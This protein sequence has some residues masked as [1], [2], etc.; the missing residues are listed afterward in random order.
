MALIKYKYGFLFI[1]DFICYI[2]T[3]PWFAMLSLFVSCFHT[4]TEEEK[5]PSRKYLHYLI[6]APILGLM[7]ICTFPMA[8]LGYISWILICNFF[9]VPDYAVL[10]YPEDRAEETKSKYTFVSANLLLGIE[11]MGK[12]QNMPFVYNRLAKI[13]KS[14]QSI[15]RERSPSEPICNAPILEDPKISDEELMDTS[16]SHKW[17]QV[18]F[19]CFQEVW[20]RVSTY[21]LVQNLYPEFKHFVVD[22]AHHSWKSN[23]FF[24]TSGL[25]IASRYPIMEVLSLIHI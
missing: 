8:V 20:D 10:S 18:D 24:G 7:V 14:F 25:M 12:F 6:C 15:N 2:M 13:A 21:K 16:V 19:M 1:L 3:Y 11:Y 23:Y 22:V 5:N 9:N 4:S 17:P